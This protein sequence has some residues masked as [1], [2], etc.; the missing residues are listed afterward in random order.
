MRALRY[1][2]CLMF[3]SLMFVFGPVHAW[4]ERGHDLVTRVAVQNL[5]VMTDDN[6]NLLRPFT[7]RDHM[8]SHFS[9]VPDIV[10]RAPYQSKQ[11]AELNPPTHYINIEKIYLGVREW[12]DLP[13]SFSQFSKEAQAKGLD[14]S[15]V[16]T[17][18][19]R[20][21]QLY[22]E[23]VLAMKS[24]DQAKNSDELE[25]RVNKV[26]LYA[27]VMSHFVGDLAN[28]H[29]TSVNHDGALTGQRGFHAYF[30]SDTVAEQ[31]FSLAQSVASQAKRNWLKQYSKKERLMKLDKKYSLVAP[32]VGENDRA[33]RKSAKRMAKY[34]KA[35]TI[36]RLG[37]GASAL[38]QLW[39]LAWQ[40]AGSPNMSEFF[41]YDY[42][43]K[44]D[45][46]P[47]NY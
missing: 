24:V 46:I 12:A 15:Q 7:L 22:K 3:L 4:G 6:T 44:P 36:E 28:P 19:W 43:V 11:V 34:Y 18:P 10:W 37:A 25:V 35:F 42:P 23:L 13:S 30:E 47:P 2:P 21:M 8:L 27:G 14:A 33:K 39:L 40:E 41:S 16:G 31:D 20:V 32:S 17:A 5:R 1:S 38:S 45:F 26:L 29:H 9:N